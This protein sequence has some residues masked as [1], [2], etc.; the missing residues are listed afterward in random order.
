MALKPHGP[1]ILQKRYLVI[2]KQSHKIKVVKYGR[3][4]VT[5]CSSKDV[6]NN[7]FSMQRF[8]IHSNNLVRFGDYNPKLTRMI[9]YVYVHGINLLQDVRQY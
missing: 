9:D 3:T 1:S 7:Y 4:C 6:L 8:D 2:K 5:E